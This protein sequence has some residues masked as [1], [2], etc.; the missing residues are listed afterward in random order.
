MSNEV[1]HFNQIKE[2]DFCWFK[3]TIWYFKYECLSLICGSFQ[4]FQD[5][6]DRPVESL[7]MNQANRFRETQELRES[8]S[9][10]MPLI[11][12]GYVWRTF[13]LV[14]DVLK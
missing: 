1:P 13:S 12:S 5:S 9:R 7:L 6:L 3:K 10:V 2:Q 14:R 8:L 4:L 11:H